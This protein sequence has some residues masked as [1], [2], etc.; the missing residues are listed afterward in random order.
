MNKELVKH[1]LTFSTAQRF[2][3]RQ[4]ED[5]EF[6]KKVFAAEMALDAEGLLPT[7]PEELE[8]LEDEAHDEM[9]ALE[10]KIVEDIASKQKSK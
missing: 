6:G 7:T 2:P 10:L 8:K 5:D 9:F 4:W 3:L 1:V